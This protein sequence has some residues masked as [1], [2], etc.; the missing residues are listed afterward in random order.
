VAI[1]MVKN[2]VLTFAATLTE[3][4]RVK[5]VRKQSIDRVN[6]KKF[7]VMNDL[8]VL[9][10]IRSNEWLDESID[11]QKFGYKFG[12]FCVVSVNALPKNARI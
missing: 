4:S 2:H 11:L 5:I 9:T 8:P 7:T 6:F 3:F 10:N 1:A 12:K